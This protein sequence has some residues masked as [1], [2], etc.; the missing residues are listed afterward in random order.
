MIEGINA[1]P[2]VELEAGLRGCCASDAWVRGMLAARPWPDV[3]TMLA[4]GRSLLSALSREEWAA[5]AAAIGE[6]PV[7]PCDEGTR[8]ATQVAL[9]LYRERFGYRFLTSHQNLDGEQLLMRIRI[10]LGHEEAAELRK[11]RFE[12][13]VL[14]CRRLEHLAGTAGSRSSL[15][16]QPLPG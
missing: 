10:R 1:L 11:S 4:D 7:P 12:H 3:A 2:A 16:A 14:V 5:A 8:R 9:E 15:G 6:W 13:V